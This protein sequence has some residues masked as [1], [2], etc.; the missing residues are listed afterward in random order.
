MMDK[1]GLYINNLMT[2]V[3]SKDEK[4]FLR[5]LA[6]EE[7]CKLKSD[8]SDFLARYVDEF[9]GIPDELK[10]K[11]TKQLILEFGEQNETNK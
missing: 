6:F 7:L 10:E 8:I 2:T 9:D 1:L 4:F 5:K 3:V 11:D